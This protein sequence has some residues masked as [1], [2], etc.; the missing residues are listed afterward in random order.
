LISAQFPQSPTPAQCRNFCSKEIPTEANN[1]SGGNWWRISDATLDD[2][3]TQVD[4]E[5]D[6]TKRKALVAQGYDAIAE[7]V[8]VI[9]IDALPTIAIYD[10]A[11]LAGSISDNPVYGMFWN[12]TEWYCKDGTC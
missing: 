9:P 11:T 12:M 8:P 3:W 5:L 2:P 10:T 1:F 4:I 7:L 6:V